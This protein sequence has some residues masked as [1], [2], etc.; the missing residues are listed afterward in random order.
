MNDKEVGDVETEIVPE[1]EMA[2]KLKLDDVKDTLN[3]VVHSEFDYKKYVAKDDSNERFLR[4]QVNTN[5]LRDTL[6]D[7][8]LGNS[9]ENENTN[10]EPELFT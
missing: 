5:S 6:F 4:K 1:L 8:L 2:A 3:D 9:Y 10:K 7:G